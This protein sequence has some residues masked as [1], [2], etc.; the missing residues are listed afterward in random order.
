MRFVVPLVIGLL[1][2]T[3]LVSLGSWQLQRLEW[4]EG[5]LSEIETRI[6]ADPVA[7]PDVPD[8]ERDRFLSVATRGQ[9]T[10]QEI[11]VLVSTK[12]VGAAF[13][14]ITLFQ[15]EDGRRLLLD[16]GI[17][18]DEAKDLPRTPVT[19]T[20]LGNLHWP[21]EIDAFTPDADRA[22]NLWYARDVDA[23]SA[24]LAAEPFLI[25]VRET[26]EETPQVTPLPVSTI[27]IPND[28]LHYA[29]TWFSLAL[30]WT[31]MT[32]YWVVRRAREKD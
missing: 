4:K 7:V 25:V 23:L 3:I 31:A 11:H 20:I 32:L 13:R 14:I 19:A 18:P 17:V 21:D 27:D 15:T 16:R 28:H 9:F 12:D 2:V 8:P 5:V 30:V 29:I 22:S 6:A 26:S 10:D 24:E 1:G